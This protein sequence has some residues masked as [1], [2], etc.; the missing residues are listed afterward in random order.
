[1]EA[2]LMF[3]KVNGLGIYPKIISKK[4]EENEEAIVIFMCS[5]NDFWNGGS[6]RSNPLH[7]DRY[8]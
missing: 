4:E 5:N 1:M 2:I 8:S 6:C 7:L 3:R